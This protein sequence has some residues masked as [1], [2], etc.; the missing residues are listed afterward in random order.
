[1]RLNFRQVWSPHNPLLSAAGECALQPLRL[2]NSCTLLRILRDAADAEASLE[3]FV[4]VVASW[5][6]SPSPLARP[7]DVVH[8]PFSLFPLPP[9]LL[10]TKG[11]SEHERVGYSVFSKTAWLVLE[12]KKALSSDPCYGVSRPPSSSSV[13]VDGAPSEKRGTRRRALRLRLG[14]L[15][16]APTWKFLFTRQ[17]NDEATESVEYVAAAAAEGEEPLHSALVANVNTG[18]LSANKPTTTADREAFAVLFPALHHGRYYAT[19]QEFAQHCLYSD[20]HLLWCENEP[21]MTVE[22][23]SEEVEAEPFV[24]CGE[25][26]AHAVMGAL[27]VGGCTRGVRGTTDRVVSSFRFSNPS[28]K[29]RRAWLAQLRGMFQRH[30]SPGRHRRSLSSSTFLSNNA[31]GVDHPFQPTTVPMGNSLLCKTHCAY[32]LSCSSDDET[33]P[34][35]DTSSAPSLPQHLP[36]AGKVDDDAFATWYGVLR[37]AC[38]GECTALMDVLETTATVGSAVAGQVREA[39]VELLLHGIVTSLALWCSQHVSAVHAAI[40]KNVETVAALLRRWWDSFVSETAAQPTQAT[41]PREML[42]ERRLVASSVSNVLQW[43]LPPANRLF[44]LPQNRN[45]EVASPN[46]MTEQSLSMVAVPS[47]LS[48]LTVRCAAAITRH[49]RCVDRAQLWSSTSND[50]SDNEQVKACQETSLETPQQ[51]SLTGTPHIS[52]EVT[53]DGRKSTP[54]GSLPMSS[55]AGCK[56]INRLSPQE[57][58]Q[59]RDN[60]VACMDLVLQLLFEEQDALFTTAVEERP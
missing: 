28:R 51:R 2:T 42:A 50:L 55:E 31:F 36:L 41:L 8:L 45:G 29:R 4:M 47:F 40:L 26:K 34:V 57:S 16:Y 27:N 53:V 20:D 19:P 39:A 18:K 10:S 60:F 7:L 9:S 56:E 25:T 59:R 3:P 54:T 49:Q 33:G 5:A 14:T 58:C 46:E 44:H 35:M 23:E 38:R 32:V 13:A 21:L 52:N 22:L 6:V 43:C 12:I 37:S 17:S 24:D 15:L 30:E 1:M 48:T 11:D